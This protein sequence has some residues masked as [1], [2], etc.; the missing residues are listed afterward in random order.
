[1]SVVEKW[2]GQTTSADSQLEYALA[3]PEGGDKVRCCTGVADIVVP[4]VIDVSEALA[5]ARRSPR[6]GA[7]GGN[8]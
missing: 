8:G 3:F 7:V 4:L 6:G 1:M 2:T 5:I